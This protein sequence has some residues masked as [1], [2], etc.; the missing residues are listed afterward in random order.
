MIVQAATPRPKLWICRHFNGQ[1]DPTIPLRQ[2]KLIISS[3]SALFW[4]DLASKIQPF[5]HV[6]RRILNKSMNSLLIK[7]FSKIYAY[8]TAS[9]DDAAFI[10]GG[11]DVYETIAEFRNNQWRNLG[12]LTKGRYY[13]GS[14]TVA[15]ET[16]IIGGYSRDSL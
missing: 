14:I 12:S 16:M 6:A 9:T 7:N 15:Q 2:G 4:V 11:Y 10:I 8:S 5:H 1:M 13:H 3:R